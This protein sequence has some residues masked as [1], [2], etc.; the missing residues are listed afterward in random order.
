MGCA[1]A[2]GRHRPAARPA[3]MGLSL[4][5]LLALLATTHAAPPP[6]PTAAI[7]TVPIIA[8]VARPA[9]RRQARRRSPSTQPPAAAYP[10]RNVH[11]VALEV[12]SPPQRMALELDTGSSDT[13]LLTP[14]SAT[15]CG[16]RVLGPF[17]SNES[18]TWTP[19]PCSGAPPLTCPKCCNT[20]T[21]EG[22]K[23]GTQCCYTLEYDD[24]SGYTANVG[25][26]TVGLPNGGP[27]ATVAVGAITDLSEGTS[28][29][30]CD[31]IM[32]LGFRGESSTNTSSALSDLL[33]ANHLGDAFAMCIQPGVGSLTLGGLPPHVG[34]AAVRYTPVVAEDYWTIW[35]ADVR[36]F[37]VS[38]GVPP[39]VY[40][41]GEAIV[42][43]GTDAWWLPRPA[44]QGLRRV[45]ESH[46][47]RGGRPSLVGLCAGGAS[48]GKTV[49]DGE[50][51]R[52]TDAEV[53]AWPTIEV[54]LGKDAERQVSVSVEPQAYLRKGWC[55]DK[56]AYWI[57]IS[58]N[59]EDE[60]S[61]LGY[62]VMV[63]RTT[64]FDR[65]RQRVGFTSPSPT[66]R[67]PTS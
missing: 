41:K 1:R 35:V 11:M 21:I 66:C 32:G 10:L 22:G 62:T 27:T 5:L 51:Y 44:W 33:R 16:K 43:D 7:V 14:C 3:M 20:S 64:V 53:A 60:G 18:R 65:A 40:N 4:L 38:V 59:D 45:M 31:G 58:A 24:G 17:R 37:G 42:D 56:Q 29:G 67:P 15:S 2:R 54:V 52:M 30:G 50:C 8:R 47:G 28:W 57:I 36:V 19:L 23:R 48:A 25:L 34:A 9:L 46:C 39:I 61:I 26:E 55:D 6:T 13:G 12:G 49:F 63:G